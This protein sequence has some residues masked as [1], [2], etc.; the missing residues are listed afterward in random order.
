MNPASGGL[1]KYGIHNQIKDSIKY[2]S[3]T[4]R[5]KKWICQIIDKMH[6]KTIWLLLFL[7]FVLVNGCNIES[8]TGQYLISG[9]KELAVKNGVFI[10]ELHAIGEDIHEFEQRGISS[11]WMEYRYQIGSTIKELKIDSS[12]QVMVFRTSSGAYELL[13][14]LYSAGNGSIGIYNGKS[15]YME[16][17][18]SSVYNIDF[19]DQVKNTLS[20]KVLCKE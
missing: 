1:M 8:R 10:C 2:Q 4:L 20:V 17:P 11:M 7:V 13:D 9:S 3:A 16:V 18:P 14:E 6:K 12:Q 15:V 19:Y 5:G